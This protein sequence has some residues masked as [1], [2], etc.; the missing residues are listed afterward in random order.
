[1]RGRRGEILNRKKDRQVAD[2]ANPVKAGGTAI[3]NMVRVDAVE[4][5]AHGKWYYWCKNGKA[6]I[7][8]LLDSEVHTYAFSVAANA[9]ISFIPFVVLLYALALSVFHSPAMKGVVDDMV[10]YFLPTAAKSKDWMVNTI[11]SEAVLPML[12][13]K[14]AQALSLVMILIAC[15]GIFLPLEVALNRAWGVTKGRNLV[16]NQLV[17]T[18]LIFVCGALALL[19]AVVTAS[20]PLLWQM[21]SGP[22]GDAPE[23]LT[24][25]FLAH[26]LFKLTSIPFTI[27]IVFLVYW[28]LPNT[29][30]PAGQVWPRAAVI[31]LLLEMLKWVNFFIW[32]ALLRKFAREYDVFKHS[33]TILTWSFLA[34][35]IV[36]AGADWSA[37]RAKR[38]EASGASYDP[39]DSPPLTAQTSIL[40]GSAGGIG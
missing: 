1:V 36:L 5:P 24:T 4:G 22:T 31:G 33:V 27:L 26:G 28:K 40:P 12:H 16:M 23:L 10:N 19:S 30:V 6:L 2:D 18:G 32:P 20:A 7:S 35:L 37:R 14:S 13:Y 8:Y 17:S 25:G 3:E 11:Y 34:G 39:G 15:T 9:I 38:A 29:K 21:I